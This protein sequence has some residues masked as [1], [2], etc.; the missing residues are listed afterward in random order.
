MRFWKI[1]SDSYIVAVG[2]GNLGEE[3]TESEYN[4]LQAVIS[5]APTAPDG[6]GYHLREDMTWELYELPTEETDP[7]LTE[8]EVLDIILGG[9]A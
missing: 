4:K 6:Y 2:I 8:A 1:A 7:E 5:S 9:E 3:V